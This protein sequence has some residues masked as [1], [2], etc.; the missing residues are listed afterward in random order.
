MVPNSVKARNLG[1][2]HASLSKIA[3][4]LKFQTLIQNL[5]C[6]SL[7]QLSLL[8]FIKGQKGRNGG[9]PHDLVL[10]LAHSASATQV[11]F[12]GMT[13]HHSSVAMLWR[14][15]SYKIQEDWHR[16]QLRANLPQQNKGRK[17]KVKHQLNSHIQIL[18]N[19][20]KSE[21]LCNSVN[22]TILGKLHVEEMNTFCVFSLFSYVW[23]QHCFSIY[24]AKHLHFCKLYFN[25]LDFS[26][27]SLSISTCM[28]HNFCVP[29]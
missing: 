29:L 12:P 10:S 23:Q 3:E 18:K 13:L 20:L 26:L 27:S 4:H 8:R 22:T 5:Y 6:L 14:R 21:F 7:S 15:P 17:K 1:G 9:R 24:L 16:C 2:R 11:W 28:R 25:I 19:L